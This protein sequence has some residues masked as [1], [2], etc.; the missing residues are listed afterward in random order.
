MLTSGTL[1][2]VPTWM[3]RLGGNFATA[4]VGLATI[5]LVWLAFAYNISEEKVRT[6]QAAEQNSSNLARAFEEQI[7]RSITAADQTLLYVRGSYAKDPAGFDISLWSKNSQFLSEFSFQVV[8]IDKDGFLVTTNLDPHPERLDLHDREHFKVHAEGNEDFL[9][10]SA[11]VLGRLSGKWSIQ[12]TRRIIAQDGS[13]GGV[14]VVS[15]DPSYLSQFYDSIDIGHK[16]AIALV[17]RDGVVRARGASGPPA[18]GVNVLG[19]NLMNELLR[20]PAG[21]FV[22]KSR[23]DGIERIYA[24][25]SVRAYPLAVVVGLATEEVFEDFFRGRNKS[26]IAAMLLSG[27]IAVASML[28]VRYQRGLAHSR[29]AAQAGTRARSEFLAMM[30]H[31]IRTPMNG[32][33]GLTDLLLDSGLSDDQR[34]L[35]GTLRDSADHLL[36]LLN[37]ILDFSKLD[38]GRLDIEQIGFDL[39]QLVRSVIELFNCR[40]ASKNL[41]LSAVFSDGVPSMV[42]GDPAR[43]RQILF[44]LIGNAIKF[45]EAGSVTVHVGC[46]PANPNDAEI[47]FRVVDTG[48]GIPPAGLGRLFEEFSQLDSS[49]SRRFGGTGLGLAICKRL[50]ACMGGEISVQS[51][52]GEGSA[53]AFSVVVQLSAALDHQGAFAE[54]PVI[55]SAGMVPI[56]ASDAGKSSRALT[57]LVAEDNM[58][59]QFVIVKMLDKLG[60]ACDLVDNGAEAV[61]AVQHGNYDVIL[62][63]MMMP[64]MD[65]LVATRII[66][67]LPSVGR[68]IHII[69][70]TA[71]ASSLDE[72]ACREAGM[73]DFVTKPLTRDRLK[74]ALARLSA[75]K[76][77]ESSAV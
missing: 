58:T 14:V 21:S 73:D 5:A 37:D 77:V 19:S 44:N 46:G 70:L 49:I 45:T 28:I 32:V 29:D 3:A 4:L 47:L 33:I 55:A 68:K 15:L 50:V 38:A 10:I 7:I 51:K 13:F 8:V 54:Q 72:A 53:F 27:F 12:L 17:G 48:I 1:N 9:Y 20:K 23:I 69:A 31:E 71:N 63:D 62:M 65:G 11:P 43:I 52:V 26:L 2:L 40:A 76:S 16:G 6:E 64:E 66:R 75:P 57:I 34:K 35:A 61:A 59:N 39:H 30:S 22:G 74:A 36:Q 25:R 18:V 67:Q 42:S 41:S 60:Y 56:S 24:F